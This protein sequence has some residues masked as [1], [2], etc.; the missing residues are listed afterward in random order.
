[1][2]SYVGF[3]P[4]SRE[5]FF[6]IESDPSEVVATSQLIVA[7]L[8]TPQASSTFEEEGTMS[9]KLSQGKGDRWSEVPV[10]GLSV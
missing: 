8:S 3:Q 5:F 10:Y 9:Q 6:S 1:M 2:E 7:S 4:K